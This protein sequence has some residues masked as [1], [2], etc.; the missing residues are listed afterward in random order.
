MRYSLPRK[1]S[2]AAATVFA[3]AWI[4]S[5]PVWA[6]ICCSC[7]PTSNVT[8]KTC[9]TSQTASSCAGLPTQSSNDANLSGYTCTDLTAAACQPVATSGGLCTQGPTD[10]TSFN[11]SASTANSADFTPVIPKLNV[12]IP[13]LVLGQPTLSVG[14]QGQTISTP[15]IGEYIA[16]AYRYLLA[17]SV[18]AAAVMITFG[19]F[20][21]I[22]GTTASSVSS[23]KETIRDAVIGLFL[24]F[25]AYTIL[26]TFSPATVTLNAIQVSLIKP[27]PFNSYMGAV[28]DAPGVLASVGIQP[29]ATAVPAT[30][31]AQGVPQTGDPSQVDNNAPLTGVPNGPAVGAPSQ[32]PS[33][34]AGQTTQAANE[35]VPPQSTA[36]NPTNL[37]IPVDCPGRD[38]SVDTATM[39]VL[40]GKPIF[41]A[42][43]LAIPLSADVIQKYLQYQAQTG[44]P[45]AVLIAQVMSE[46][47]GLA[48]SKCIIQ[49]MFDNPG[50]C[51]SSPYFK[52]NNFGGVGCT[53]AQ[54]GGVCANIAVA[55]PDQS[56]TDSDGPNNFNRY[57]PTCVAACTGA[58]Q[59]NYQCGPNCFPL[60]IKKQVSLSSSANWPGVQCSREFATPQD[61][62]NSHLGF[63]APCLQYNDSVYKFA[64]CIGASTYAG[65]GNKGGYLAAVIERNCLCGSK[66]SSGCKRDLGLEDALSK[67]VIAKTNLYKLGGNTQAIAQA[68]AKATNGA[69]T[70]TEYLQTDGITRIA[71]P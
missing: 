28:Q 12:A 24:V 21:Y 34:T 32:I 61:F 68:L 36:K 6:A 62:L 70:P 16:A 43:N 52:Y 11:A 22:L 10:A 25:G 33:G 14:A 53:E 45:A 40:G 42:S 38:S 5:T 7:Y 49:H 48:S 44:V 1:I 29:R 69:L 63:V 41:K 4:A 23:G 35:Y 31:I 18:I 2:S 8:N 64:Y 51:G 47:G 55:N 65:D 15:F 71:N 46:T 67:K 9:L 56:C 3:L 59:S 13:G 58:T 19:G 66:D 57:S 17:I 54:N 30:D 50:Q 27:D 26:Q 39:L 37:T 20:K 60:A